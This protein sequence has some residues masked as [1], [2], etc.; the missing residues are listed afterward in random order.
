MDDDKSKKDDIYDDNSETVHL[1]IATCADKETL[2]KMLIEFV[3]VFIPDD[4]ANA[5]IQNPSM[6]LIMHKDLCGRVGGFDIVHRATK[7]VVA[8]IDATPDSR[9]LP[10]DFMEDMEAKL[11]EIREHKNDFASMFDN[12]LGENM[13]EEEIK[14][15]LKHAN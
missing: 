9:P 10:A 12:D 1:D 2:I 14:E 8:G 5:S 7:T 6:L 15:R 4:I 3:N 11:K 13:S